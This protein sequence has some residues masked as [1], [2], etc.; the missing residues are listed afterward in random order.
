MIAGLDSLVGP[1]AKAL[2]DR[3]DIALIPIQL[4]GQ[5]ATFLRI[6]ACQILA[7][8]ADGIRLVQGR[9]L[10]ATHNRREHRRHRQNKSRETWTPHGCYSRVRCCEAMGTGTSPDTIYAGLARFGSDQVPILSQLGRMDRVNAM[11][12]ESTNQNRASRSLGI[13]GAM[14]PPPHT[15]TPLAPAKSSHPTQLEKSLS[16][17]AI[18]P[19]VRSD[20]CA[21]GGA[22]RAHASYEPIGGSPQQ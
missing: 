18:H 9:G 20:A 7:S 15:T 22:H 19:I 8:Q 1:L 5:T 10:R 2:D 13:R 12:S 11:Y 4:D 6:M 14:L 17:A 21:Y 3:L 16:S